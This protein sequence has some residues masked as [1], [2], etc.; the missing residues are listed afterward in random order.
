MKKRIFMLAVL[1]LSGLQFAVAAIDEQLRALITASDDIEVTEVTNDEAHPWTVADGMASSTVG[2]LRQYVSSS[3]TIK[4]TT[5]KPIIMRYDFTFDPYSSNDSRKVYIDGVAQVDSYAPYKTKATS[6]FYFGMDEGEHVFT[7]THYHSYSV[8]DSYTQV[9]TIGNI[10]FESV[11]SQYMNIHLSAP[12]TLGNEALAHVNTL[13]EMRFLRLSGKM[14]ASDWNDI[15]KMT[16]LTAIDMTNVDIETIPVKAFTNTSIRFIDFPTKL[17]TIGDNAFDNRFLTG[18]LVLP[19]GLDSIGKEAFQKNYITEVTIPESVRAIGQSAFY[20]NQS[21][22]SVTLNNRMETIN[23]S[24]FNYCQKLAVVRGGKNVKIVDQTAFAGCDSLRSISDITP[25]TI[26][27]SAFYNCRKLESLNFS[28]IK[29]IG[30]ESFYNCFG[31][32]EADLTT[33]T[34]INGRSFIGCTGL[35]KV[36]FGNDITTIKSEAFSTCDALE[37]VVLGSSINSLESNCFYSTKNA[38]KRVYITA[39]APPAVGSAPFYSPT[40]VTLYVPEYAMVSYKLDNYWSQFTKVEPN[41]NQPDKVN[42]YKKLELTSNAR[43]P[44]SPDMYLGKGGALIVNGDN[45]QTF[46]KYT[47]YMNIGETSSSLISRCKEMTST[48]SQFDFFIGATSGSGY[49]YYLCMPF[50]VKRSDIILPEGTAI[51]VRY[52]DSESRATNGASGNWKD[53]PADSILH[54]GK[55]Y[56]FRSSK[57]GNVGFPATEETHNAIFRSEAVSAPLVQYPAVESANAGWNLVGNPYPCFYDIYYMDFAAPITAWDVDNRTY[58]A[59]SATDDNFVLTPQQ[60]FFVQKPELVDAIT[61]QPAGRQINKTIDHSAL[62]MRRAARSQQVQ[63]KLVDVALTCDDRTDRTRVVVNAN[64]SDDFCAD[65][66]AVKM[67]AYEGT[68]QIYT[69]AGA[70]QLAVNEGAH[71]DGSVAL[72]MYLPA[73]DAYTIAVDRDELGVKLLDYGVE[74]EMPY[75]FS[76]AEG[77]MDDRFTLTFEAPTTGINTVA[78]DADADNAIY[79]IDGRRVNSTAQKGIYI[80]NHKKIVK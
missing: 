34:S 74:V 77:Y 70:D 58:K 45:A 27:R 15:S 78:T 26:N 3:I 5:K 22:K 53:V 39:P 72:G 73:D 62:A 10:R 43:I 1:I 75:T 69:I 8:S 50:D 21:L 19:E 38:L 35:K 18:P 4:F 30:Y 44:N 33:L 42:L 48:S 14:N 71:R 46:G 61:F 57:E 31:L 29:S 11:E 49:W 60:A 51:A 79:T 65:N 13:P 63:R 40:S 20:D 54:M 25:V 68:P 7:Y 67:M 2:K 23:R 55:G 41:P 80:Q 37:E 36:T 47:Q 17:K 66:D 16:G 12:G 76:A 64:A 28:R 24:L 32:K 56:I 9:L 52:Y 6:T 59:Y